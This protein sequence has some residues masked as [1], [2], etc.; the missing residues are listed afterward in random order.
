MPFQILQR[1]ARLPAK[2]ARKHNILRGCARDRTIYPYSAPV[3]FGASEGLSRATIVPS[4]PILNK[5]KVMAAY[6]RQS[7]S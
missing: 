1:G 3:R 5:F 4:A 7:I 2:Y 6:R